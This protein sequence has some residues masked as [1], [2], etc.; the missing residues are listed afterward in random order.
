MK[1]LFCLILVIVMLIPASIVSA[2]GTTTR[3]VEEQTDKSCFAG[4]ILLDGYVGNQ[5]DRYGNLYPFKK[6][7]PS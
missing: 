3:Q 6:V 1:K 5:I 7:A 4:D 2:A